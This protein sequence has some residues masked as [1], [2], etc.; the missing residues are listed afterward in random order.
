MWKLA[1]VVRLAL[2]SLVVEAALVLVLQSGRARGLGLRILVVLGVLLLLEAV[3]VGQ[4]GDHSLGV[5]PVQGEAGGLLLQ[6]QLELLVIAA[7]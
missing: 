3:E 4:G 6:F 2:G 5:G 7:L 1:L